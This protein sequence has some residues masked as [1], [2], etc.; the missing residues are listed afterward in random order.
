MDQKQLREWLEGVLKATGRNRSQ[1]GVL[2]QGHRSAGTKIFNGQRKITVEDLEKLQ[3]EWG[4]A[5]PGSLYAKPEPRSGTLTQHP[6]RGGIPVRGRIASHTWIV[7]EDRHPGLRIGGVFD[8]SYPLSDQSAYQ[9]DSPGRPGER[10]QV[11]DFVITVPFA[12]Y[13]AKVLVGDVIVTRRI[14]QRLISYDLRRA[15][16]IGDKVVLQPML[17]GSEGGD[18][19]DQPYGLVIALQTS[20]V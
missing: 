1:L 2:L 15:V 7:E 13:R 6:D 17:E 18:S 19:T 3:R 11:G 10:Y 12:S 4:V 16:E 9:I 8:K 14:R 20:N 5:P